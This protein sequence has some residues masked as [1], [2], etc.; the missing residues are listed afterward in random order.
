MS[1]QQ[2]WGK[3]GT[4]NTTQTTSVPQTSGINK[5]QSVGTG[6]LKDLLNSNLVSRGFGGNATST[7][8][9]PSKTVTTTSDFNVGDK[10]EHKKFG[11]GSIS[12]ATADNGDQ[13]LEIHF[14]GSGMKRLMGSL[15]NLKRLE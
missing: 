14:E 4:S 1:S 11:K 8:S 9:V 13:M 10:V 5:N 6:S 2:T 12:K 7:N 15:A 3:T